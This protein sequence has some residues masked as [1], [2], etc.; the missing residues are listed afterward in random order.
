MRRV[1]GM[2]TANSMFLKKQVWNRWAEK[3]FV[4]KT[5]D[6]KFYFQQTAIMQPIL[7]SYAKVQA[8]VKVSWFYRW[9]RASKEPQRP[10]ILGMARILSSVMRSVVMRRVQLYFN[11]VNC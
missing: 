2:M 8:R 5:Q 3:L 4:Y 9:I 10:R 11:E 1:W 6:W 7:A